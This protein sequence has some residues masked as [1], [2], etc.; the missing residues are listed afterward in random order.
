MGDLQ[1]NRCRVDSCL[2]PPRPAP[3]R[4]YRRCGWALRFRFEKSGANFMGLCPFHG[5]KSP[6]S[7]SARSNS[8]D[9]CFG[10]GKG[11]DAIAFLLDHT[12][13]ELYRRR[14]RTW[15]SRRALQV[16]QENSSPQQRAQRQAM[17][18]AAGHPDRCPGAGRRRRIA[19][20]S[21]DAP[22]AIEYFKAPGCLGRRSPPVRAWATPRQGWRFS[23]PACSPNT[24]AACWKKAAW[25]STRAEDEGK[26]YDRFRDRMMFPIRNVKGAV[27]R[28]WRARALGDDKPK[29]LNSPETPVFHK[30]RELYGLFEA[31]TALRDTATPWCTEGYTGR[32]GAGPAGLSQ[33]RGHAWAQPAPAEHVHKLFRF[34]EAVVFSFDGD[35]AGQR[36]ARKAL[37]AVL[38]LRQR[39][40]QRQVSV[41]PPRAR[42]GQLHPRPMGPMPLR[43]MVHAG[44]AVQPIFAASGQRGLRPGHRRRSRPNCP[45]KPSRCGTD[46]RPGALKRLVLDELAELITLPATSWSAVGSHPA[47]PEATCG[48]AAAD[49]A[50]GAGFRRTSA[51]PGSA[52]Q[53]QTVRALEKSRAGPLRPAPRADAPR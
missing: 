36:A 31:R 39:H 27:H 53:A 14:C 37:E 19:N 44:H 8:F 18:A 26:R 49:G 2:L 24:P 12:G 41:L 30:G 1:D 16:P 11:G 29:Y 52:A 4:R 10:C 6:R 9:H 3:T 42:P 48:P 23:W 50:P 13:M 5:K 35:A 40:A 33:C 25:S 28:L 7:A 15:P 38:P 17:N 32:G 22:H 20:S 43:R 46:C 51:S 21:S 34:T 45:T 47:Q